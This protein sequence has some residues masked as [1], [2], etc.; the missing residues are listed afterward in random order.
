[1]VIIF[2]AYQRNDQ[3]VISTDSKIHFLISSLIWNVNTLVKFAHVKA[4]I[5]IFFS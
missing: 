3:R 1:M 5:D 2:I 4:I